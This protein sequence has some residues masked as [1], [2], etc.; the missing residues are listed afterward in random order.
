MNTETIVPT[1]PLARDT[2]GN[3]IDVPANATAWRVR[4]LAAKAGRPKLIYDNETGLPL[5]LPL[6]ASILE[7]A[8]AVSEDGRFRLEAVDQQGRA[9]PN[10]VA[11]TAFEF[12][13]EDAAPAPVAPSNM[14]E[15]L[16][17]R[18]IDSNTRV[19]EALAS[20]FA[21]VPPAVLPAPQANEPAPAV[22]NQSPFGGAALAEVINQV[23]AQIMTRFGQ[24]QPAGAPNGT[25]VEA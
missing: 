21:M 14:M 9:I 25:K 2:D 6:T 11:V 23:L 4:K 15:Q 13:E 10:C 24:P 7:L 19:T 3:P 8:E 5:E 16:M 20:R 1:Y 12:P 22:Q 17:C 18:L